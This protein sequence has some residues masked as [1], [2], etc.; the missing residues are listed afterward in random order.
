MS[1]LKLLFQHWSMPEIARPAGETTGTRSV[2]M[3]FEHIFFP[4]LNGS[5]NEEVWRTCHA[6]VNNNITMIVGHQQDPVQDFI[7]LSNTMDMAASGLTTTLPQS[8][9]TPSEIFTSGRLVHTT[10]DYSLQS[11]HLRGAEHRSNQAN[12][13][14]PLPPPSFSLRCKA[15]MARHWF[16]NPS[17]LPTQP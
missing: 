2:S 17:C 6:K 15:T 9:S 7:F 4:R 1:S 12:R 13:A 10:D 11:V 14:V 5:R 3:V 16:T 8:W